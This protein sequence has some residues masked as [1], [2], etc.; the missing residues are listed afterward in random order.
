VDGDSGEGLELDDVGR[1]TGWFSGS[2]GGTFD[3]PGDD[4]PCPA[5]C[6]EGNI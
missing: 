6:G 4:G 2:P 1:L 5:I 3:A